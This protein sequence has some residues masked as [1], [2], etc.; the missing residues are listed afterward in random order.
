MQQMQQKID[1]KDYIHFLYLIFLHATSYN[2]IHLH[3]GSIDANKTMPDFANDVY[4]QS[5]S[6]AAQLIQS[7]YANTVI[8]EYVWQFFYSG[9]S[10]YPRRIYKALARS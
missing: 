10:L 6:M 9:R 4:V 3:G 8:H 5:S 2:Q 7:G 1:L